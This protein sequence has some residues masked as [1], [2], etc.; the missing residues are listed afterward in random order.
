MNISAIEDYAPAGVPVPSS[1]IIIISPNA[2]EISVEPAEQ[3]GDHEN[4]LSYLVR[5]EEIVP[6][7][8]AREE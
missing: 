7:T 5:I 8:L 3:N 6:D 4:F 2:L 1:G